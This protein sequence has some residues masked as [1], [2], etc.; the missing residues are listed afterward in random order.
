MNN[1]NYVN[2]N[3]ATKSPVS[4]TLNED[5]IDRL[6]NVH[7]K[8][9]YIIISACR[10]DWDEKNP[11]NNKTINKQKTRELQSDIHKAG[12]TFTPVYGG[13]L[14]EIDGKKVSVPGE[15]SMIVYNSGKDGKALDI[16]KIFEFGKALTK[17]YNQYS[18]YFKKPGEKPIWADRNGKTVTTFK[19]NLKIARAAK[20]A[21]EKYYTDFNNPK[22]VDAGKLKR[23]SALEEE[24]YFN[25]PASS[26]AERRARET[27]GEIILE[28]KKFFDY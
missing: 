6:L 16:N 2:L 28:D 11:E 18:F 19:E 26:F 1:E 4:Y 9:G 22:K 24:I 10:E 13:S 21:T 17:K 3:E 5:K 15:T 7:E 8:N 20:E 27:S 23:F 14:E 25:P 12:Y